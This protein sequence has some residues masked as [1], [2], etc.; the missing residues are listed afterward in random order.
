L[1]MCNRAIEQDSVYAS[2]YAGLGEA[3][4]RKYE[5]SKDVTAILGETR[6]DGFRALGCW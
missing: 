2:A 4:W 6:R 3:Y 5:A 1:V